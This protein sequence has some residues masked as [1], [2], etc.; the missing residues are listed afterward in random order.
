MVK[1][2]ALKSTDKWLLLE[3][4]DKIRYFKNRFSVFLLVFSFLLPILV[5]IDSIIEGIWKQ[6]V[7]VILAAGIT[8]SLIIELTPIPEVA[9]L[10][11]SLGTY[12]Y[13]LYYNITRINNS[14]TVLRKK[15]WKLLSTSN[16]RTLKSAKSQW[17]AEGFIQKKTKN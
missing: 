11:T 3:R 5:L 2:P 9:M 6:V 4:E 16:Q 17:E 1:L 7:L 14:L 10:I 13:V 15:G 12:L 8:G